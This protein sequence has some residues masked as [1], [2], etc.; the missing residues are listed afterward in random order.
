MMDNSANLQNPPPQM[1]ENLP[2]LPKGQP[3]E[4]YLMIGCADRALQL[5]SGRDFGV[6]LGE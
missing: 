1:E 2:E 3:S 6:G 4:K 5:F